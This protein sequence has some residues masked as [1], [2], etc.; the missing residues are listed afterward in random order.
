[1]PLPSA[2]IKNL[3]STNK[4][5]PPSLY[6]RVLRIV[7]LM[8]ALLLAAWCLFTGITYWRVHIL[9]PTVASWFAGDAI[10]GPGELKQAQQK[11]EQFESTLSFDANIKYS[12]AQL[13]IVRGK[14][15]SDRYYFDA[16]RATLNQAQALQPSYYQA[17]ALQVYLDDY[18]YGFNDTTHARLQQLLGLSPYEKKVQML[19]GPVLVKRWFE[20]SD[21]LQTMAKPLISSALR[22][23]ATKARL[24][25]AMQQ[26]NVVS[27]FT[28]CSPNR[29]TSAQLRVMEATT[30]NAPHE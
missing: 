22:E 15:Q 24:F 9:A 28:C 11:F 3:H 10:A 16:A 1:M 21:E 6:L 23:A 26:Y 27:P 18:Y 30:A 17:L 20:L 19:I 12:L 13:Y 8:S 29:E 2:Y 5:A 7:L 25:E 14:S 4:V